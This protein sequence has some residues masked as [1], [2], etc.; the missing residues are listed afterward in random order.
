MITVKIETKDGVIAFKEE[1]ENF[2]WSLRNSEALLFNVSVPTIIANIV[3][4]SIDTSLDSIEIGDKIIVENEKE[5]HKLTLE[6]TLVTILKD[7]GITEIACSAQSFKDSKLGKGVYALGAEYLNEKVLN[8][9]VKQIPDK[10]IEKGYAIIKRNEELLLSYL[11]SGKELAYLTPS[12]YTGGDREYVW[13]CFKEGSS[14]IPEYTILPEDIVSFDVSPANPEITELRIPRKVE[15]TPESK[16]NLPK[17]Q[18]VKPFFIPSKRIQAVY[19]SEENPFNTM[20]MQEL[21]WSDGHVNY[22][23]TEK[24][25]FIVGVF[26]DSYIEID[27]IEAI[28][29]I[30]VSFFAN[31]E[32][33]YAGMISDN[34]GNSWYSWKTA[35]YDPNY[36]RLV[37]ASRNPSVGDQATMVEYNTVIGGWS[38][39]ATKGPI[40]ETTIGYENNA[41][42]RRKDKYTDA[43]LGWITLLD[44][45]DYIHKFVDPD[46]F[47]EVIDKP[48]ITS[49]VNG[50]EVLWFASTKKK[51]SNFIVGLKKNMTLLSVNI[52]AGHTVVDE[53]YDFISEFYIDASNE[54]TAIYAA[55]YYFSQK[56][57]SYLRIKGN[58]TT[59]TLDIARTDFV[60]IGEDDQESIVDA[61]DGIAR[62]SENIVSFVINTRYSP[63]QEKT[64]IVN[65]DSSGLLSDYSIEGKWQYLDSGDPDIKSRDDLALIQLDV[66][67]DELKVIQKIDGTLANA[68]TV[69]SITREE[70]SKWVDRLR[71]W[72]IDYKRYRNNAVYAYYN[73][74]AQDSWD[75]GVYDLMLTNEVVPWAS[76]KVDTAQDII[77]L[78]KGVE[79]SVSLPFIINNSIKNMNIP[80]EEK[81]RIS[82]DIAAFKAPEPSEEPDEIKDSSLY[83]IWWEYAGTIKTLNNVTYHSWI[84]KNGAYAPSVKRMGTP[85]RNP[86]I[87]DNITVLDY[88]NFMGGWT[89][90]GTTQVADKIGT[91]LATKLVQDLEM[92]ALMSYV[93]VY[94][95]E[96]G[97]PRKM[98]VIGIDLEYRGI[99]RMRVQGILV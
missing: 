89:T 2:T 72:Y 79:N 88:S 3:L 71:F 85:T 5:E 73:E 56:N 63:Y 38:T 90:G 98:K 51:D 91:V 58:A 31:V 43:S 66:P 53:K 1:I 18:L 29:T 61:F 49:E 87:G 44:W 11:W 75:E 4:H 68:K 41:T 76:R 6:V 27:T 7:K 32:W 62:G 97:V 35:L 83:K 20:Q 84:A 48:V 59:L 42:L 77:K 99:I 15:G 50:Q 92:P 45:E 19:V 10:D 96:S 30:K 80:Y 37:T 57:L 81:G 54:I 25:R 23:G 86:S 26:E 33:E 47:A 24:R 55:P 36:T 93:D 78:K 14:E 17:A 60:D 94:T 74:V 95:N 67:K 16:L 64:Y 22:L 34:P 28:G 8:F 39:T 65:M 69:Q 13:T 40:T 52:Q 21:H 82:L 70:Y 46:A 12:E 9:K